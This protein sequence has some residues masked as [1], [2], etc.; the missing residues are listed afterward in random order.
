MV[1][2]SG[3]IQLYNEAVDPTFLPRWIYLARGV[4]LR[5]VFF[6]NDVTSELY[7]VAVDPTC[8]PRWIYLAIEVLLRAVLFW[9]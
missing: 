3:A 4:L 5:A 2:A 8:L 9:Q 7:N 6:G 1:N